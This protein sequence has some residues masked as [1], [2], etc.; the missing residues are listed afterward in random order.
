MAGRDL[1]FQ[2]L[3]PPSLLGQQTEVTTG[4]SFMLLTWGIREGDMEDKG[5][6]GLESPASTHVLVRV[7]TAEKKQHKHGSSC[8]GKHF[9]GAGLVHYH[10]ESMVACRQNSGKMTQHVKALVM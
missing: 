10:G 6:V 7:S 5:W 2:R 3:L 8:K 9:T 4:L 1:H